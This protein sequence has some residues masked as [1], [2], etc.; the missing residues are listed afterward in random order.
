MPEYTYKDV[1]ID[2][3]DPRVE[4]GEE[5]IFGSS[6]EYLLE[7]CSDGCAVFSKLKAVNVGYYEPF[8]PSTEDKGYPICIRK[9]EPK[10]K[11][12]PFDLSDPDV[13]KS[14]RGRWITDGDR[15]ESQITGFLVDSNGEWNATTCDRGLIDAINLQAFWK[16]DDG[17]PCGQLVEG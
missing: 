12:V 1:I 7:R 4:I 11:Y 14:L 6:P 15:E 8:V 13:R 5:Y 3:E 17:T 10:K 16:F 9:K 2:P